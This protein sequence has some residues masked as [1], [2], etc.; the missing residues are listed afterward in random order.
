M[1]A[2]QRYGPGPGPDGRNGASGS[3][4]LLP[5]PHIDDIIA[6]PDDIDHN[7]SVRTLLEQAAKALR[8]AEMSRGL[9]R[10]AHALK[11]YLRATIILVQVI[12]KHRDYPA[13][14]NTPSELGRQHQML[15][16]KTSTMSAEYTKIK[17]EIIAD[18]KKTGVQPLVKRPHGGRPTG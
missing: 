15:L 13:L 14:Q 4:R 6:M 9:G 5:L 8:L 1:A 11:E 12:A 2:D 10:P 7:H 18:N 16:K 17:Q 3:Q